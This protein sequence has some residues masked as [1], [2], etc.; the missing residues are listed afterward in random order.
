MAVAV[1]I[2]GLVI[3]LLGLLVVG[4]LRSHAE[5]LAQLHALEEGTG[6]GEVRPA[7]VGA[8]TPAPAKPAFDIMGTSLS[9]EVVKVGVAGARNDTLLAF[10]TSGCFTCIGFWDTF[11]GTR[12][13]SVP[14]GARL[15]IVTKDPAEESPSRLAELAP[16]DHTV[17]MSSAAW[18]QYGVPVAPYFVYV[19]GSAGS[20]I[21]GG[22]ASD[23]EQV[24]DLWSK[25]VAKSGAEAKR[26][27]GGRARAERADGELARAGIR[28]GD[29]SLYPGKE[30]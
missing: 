11:R 12:R 14:G 1:L 25:A 24:T 27:R 13:L 18:A 9:D 6:A 16:K 29:P 2:E 17:V 4:L 23:W 20:V 19:D 21:A 7:A 5:I 15:V 28:P 10:L 8:A 22:G 26:G 30:G 3:A